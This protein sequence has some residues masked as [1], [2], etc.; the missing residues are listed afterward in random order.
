MSLLLA[1]LMQAGPWVTARERPV[2]PLPPEMRNRPARVQP[3]TAP[4][5]P[6]VVKGDSRL[7]SCL[8]EATSAPTLAAQSA[9]AWRSS[10]E[11]QGQAGPLH[12][13]GAAQAGLEQW[14]EAE[15]SFLAAQGLAANTAARA[16]YGA[17]AG[18]AALA[19]AA[20]TRALGLLDMAL[21][22]AR[23][24]GAKPLGASIELDRARALVALGR[25]DEAGNAL[26]AAR[27]DDPANPEAF[28]LSATLM[29]RDNK[30]PEAQ[31][32]IEQ[33]AKLAPADAD[34]GL[35]AGVIAV[36]AG[37]DEAARKSWQSV[38]AMAPQSPQAATAK[39]YLAQLG[40][41]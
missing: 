23:S 30:L 36:L 39:G 25:R 27:S 9:Q 13:L 34:I 10:A 3:R 2:S 12:C 6:P 35:E 38:I 7:Q 15:A 26:A 31:T 1:L 29:R 28:L 40:A 19:Q 32:M 20:H 22:D 14:G 5:L 4:P 8:A 16:A 41:K 17:M 24:A 21:V 18:N 33:A 37:R 11:G